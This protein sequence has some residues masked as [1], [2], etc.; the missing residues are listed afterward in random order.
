MIKHILEDIKS[1]V[2]GSNVRFIYTEV[3]DDRILIGADRVLKQKL[4]LPV[5]VGNEKEA[6]QR[7]EK[8]K[9]DHTKFEI[10]EPE[11][12]EKLQEYA[13]EFY[14]MRKHKGIMKEEALK[15]MKQPNYFGTMMLYKNEG[16]CLVSGAHYTT[17]ETLRPALQIIGVSPGIK[18]ASS[19]FIMT[20]KG[21]EE[22][23]C[24]FADCAVVRNPSA[25]EL[26]EIA[27]QTADSAKK[28]GIS[29]RI[30]MLSYSTKGSGFGEPVDKVR[31]ATE[32]VK[33]KRPNL[34][35]DGELQLDAAIVPEVAR[36]KCPNSPIKGDANVLIF[37]DLNSGNIGYKL[38][39]RFDGTTATGPIVQGLDKHLNVLSRGCSADDVVN[40]SAI[41]I[42]QVLE[43]KKRLNN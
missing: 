34:V 37:P 26:S 6:R 23:I 4:A 29:P 21:E 28:F 39:E 32:I 13:E 14:N 18:T 9:I 16:D 41:T 42:M 22:K 3:N 1:K 25:E 40:V 43:Q 11:K 7:M 8:L 33:K 27:I 36:L 31:L 38:V 15:L 2:K 10:I 17:A 20:F 24:F 12:S 30:A 19:F 35:I 5:F